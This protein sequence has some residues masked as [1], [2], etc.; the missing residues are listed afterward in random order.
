M[1]ARGLIGV[2]AVLV[3]SLAFAEGC[4]LLGSNQEQA[5]EEQSSNSR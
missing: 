4:N 2:L 1:K 5:L 3:L